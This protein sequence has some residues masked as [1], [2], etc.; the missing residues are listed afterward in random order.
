MIGSVPSDTGPRPFTTQHAA[1]GADG[2]IILY[3]T[4]VESDIW[5][6]SVDSAKADTN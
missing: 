4:P 1:I 6:M 2:S 5:Q 3:R